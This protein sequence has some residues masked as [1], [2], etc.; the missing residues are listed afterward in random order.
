MVLLQHDCIRA[1]LPVSV[2][3]K[4]STATSATASGG[5]SSGATKGSAISGLNSGDNKNAGLDRG[6]VYKINIDH[7]IHRIRF[8]SLLLMIKSYFGE[9]GV[10]IMECLIEN[11]KI[12][13]AHICRDVSVAIESSIA[14][15]G[16]GNG[17]NNQDDSRSR[18]GILTSSSSSGSLTA[19]C[20][21]LATS[22]AGNNTSNNSNS[23]CDTNGDDTSLAMMTSFS[24][25]RSQVEANFLALIKTQ[26]VSAV[27]S[28]LPDTAGIDN[29]REEKVLLNPN[30]Q[31]FFQTATTSVVS[32]STKIKA[33]SGK[34]N[35]KSYV[36][37]ASAQEEDVTSGD[38]SGEID[39]VPMELRIMMRNVNEA[40]SGTIDDVTAIAGGVGNKNT[41]GRRRGAATAEVK[42]STGVVNDIE[43]R[44]RKRRV[45]EDDVEDYN[46]SSNDKNRN[47]E[48]RKEV[49]RDVC[50]G[51]ATSVGSDPNDIISTTTLW[52]IN[53]AAYI[54]AYRFNLCIEFANERMG[55]LASTVLKV[56]LQKT[57]DA[58]V[59]V[60]NANNS[61][62]YSEPISLSDIFKSV[63]SYCVKNNTGTGIVNCGL[64]AAALHK[65]MPNVTVLASLMTL[66]ELDELVSP[67][68]NITSGGRMT[69]RRYDGSLLRSSI[70][71]VANSDE[72]Y[73]VNLSKII[74]ARKQ[75][76]IHNIISEKY[77]LHSARIVELLRKH[78]YV[79]QQRL[80]D[81]AILPAKDAREKLYMLFR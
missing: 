79:D 22:S 30:S 51:I 49:N 21:A 27:P 29:Q 31:D 63:Q 38:G 34:L 9:I 23:T 4:D 16:D 69:N 74:A 2:S 40:R 57:I 43:K 36:V 24:S 13:Y 54:Q 71:H 12:N 1:E 55:T 68:R 8:P 61:R 81:L 46:N 56:M 53:W 73:V 76:S 62:L 50:A 15:N 44:K 66:M 35:S 33:K 47:L 72:C 26:F 65:A 60:G 70:S 3:S 32:S 58:W 10:F 48:E 14:M 28:L 25:I 59:P 78:K 42:S 37:A 7:I 75:K 18:K 45:V 67:L 11:G 6:F 39:S 5:N 77:G 19:M 20:S 64:T 17:G 80:S 41:K 52:R